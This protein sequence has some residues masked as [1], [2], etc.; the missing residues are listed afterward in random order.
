M[1]RTLITK[2]LSGFALLLALQLP[3]QAPDLQ[4]VIANSVIA[5]QKDF[6]AAPRYNWKERDRT[7]A[8][9]KTYQVTMIEG[10]PYYRLLAENDQPLSPE[11]QQEEL[12]KQ[13][14]A[15]EKR[16]SESP[17]A[18][19]ARIAKFV[20]DRTRDQNMTEQLTKAFNFTFVGTKKVRG[21]EVWVLKATPRPGYQP[22]NMDAQVL[23]GT[24]GELWIDQHSYQWVHVH[25]TVI[26]PVSIEGFLARVEP[27]TQF[28]LQKS[29]I[30]D[31]IWQPSHYSMRA[32]AKVLFMF[33]HSSQ[34][35]DTYWDYEPAT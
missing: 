14:H 25:A 29:P 24:Q 8:G 30:G 27:G 34:E 11:R 12:Q 6:D 1:S 22:P 26:R 28:D 18:R 21:F 5:N 10:T 19:R 20:K 16:R 35:D 23:L 13:Q 17:E 15:T 32:Q 7:P 3:G 9:S 4:E 2:P 33:N 31:G